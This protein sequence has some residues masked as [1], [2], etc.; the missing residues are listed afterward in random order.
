MNDSVK[1]TVDNGRNN[2]SFWSRDFVIGLVG[3]FFL[4]M[5]VTLFYMLPLFLGRFNPSKSRVGLIMGVHSVMAILIRPVFGRL[6]DVR[7]GRKI[8]L[9]GIGLLIA[10]VPFFHLVRDAGALPLLLRALTGMGWGVS[11]TATIAVCSDLAPVGSLARSMGIIGVAGLVANALGPLAAEEI[12][13]RWGFGWLFNF[14]VIFLA[15]AFACVLY[16]KDIPRDP[17]ASA[18]GSSGLKNAAILTILII[19]AMPVFHGAVRGTMIY[20]IALFANSI[21]IGRVGPFFVVFSLAAILTRFGMADL[22]DRFGRKR[23]IIPAAALISVNLLIISLM[24]SPGLFIVTGFLGGLGQ[25]LIFPALSTYFIDFLGRENKGMA[26]SLYS[27]LFDVGMG[28]GSPFF[29]WI[30]DIWGYRRMYLFA[31]VFLFVSTIV[32]MWKAPL[33]EGDGSG[34]VPA[35]KT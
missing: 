16:I 14:G 13:N 10:T 15:A 35:Q 19:S 34:A 30:S 5:S 29:G 1:P 28:L 31:G 7:G 32:F 6:I 25:G 9:L 8:S 33:T 18:A 23:V 4:F 2:H 27:S 12:I 22:S 24:K 21:G 3:Y 26:I 17:E 11:M 20:F